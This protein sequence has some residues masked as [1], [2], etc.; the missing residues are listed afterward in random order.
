MTEQIVIDYAYEFKK[1]VD[2]ELHRR[3]WIYK[4]LAEAMG[5][6]SDVVTNAFKQFGSRNKPYRTR[7]KIRELL[8]IQDI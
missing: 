3:G 8:D 5:V 2:D 4:D 6:T 1:R 7:Q